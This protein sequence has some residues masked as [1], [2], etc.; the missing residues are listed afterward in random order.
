[1]NNEIQVQY[2]ERFTLAYQQVNF[3]MYVSPCETL[4]ADKVVLGWIYWR[5]LP[6]HYLQIIMTL[7]PYILTVCSFTSGR[8]L[9][10]A[11]DKSYPYP[12]SVQRECNVRFNTHSGTTHQMDAKSLPQTLV[13]L[14]QLRQ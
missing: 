6:F 13:V 8:I 12:N 14:P 1:M 9:G 10:R 3:Q 5:T 2:W 4:L 11:A 7:M